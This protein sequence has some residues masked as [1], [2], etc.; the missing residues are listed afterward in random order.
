MRFL[1]NENTIP[2]PTEAIRDRAI[3]VREEHHVAEARQEAKAIAE[4]LGFKRTAVYEIATS[5]T[6]L[7][8]NVFFHTKEGGEITL[9]AL[10]AGGRIGL[11]VVS[12]DGGPGIPD[13]EEALKDGFTTNGG[14][15]GG[16]PGVGRLMDEFEI[17]STV[18]LGTHIIARKW[19]PCL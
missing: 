13:V 9:C 14:L 18:D 7:A 11:E 19:Q 17:E 5:V 8:N 12:R 6:E 3:V 16:L 15:G 4:L 10:D 2:V 1:A